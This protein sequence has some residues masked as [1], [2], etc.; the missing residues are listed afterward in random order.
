M[1]SLTELYRIGPGPSSSHTLGPQRAALMFKDEFK[2]ATSYK[3]ILYGSLALTGKGHYTDQILIKTMLPIPCEIVFHND[4]EKLKHPNTLVFYAYK[5]S[6]CIGEW[7]V[8]SV[9]GGS[10]EIEGRASIDGKKLYQENTFQAIHNYCDQQNMS[11]AQYIDSY[12]QID[13]YLETIMNQMLSTVYQGINQDGLLPGELQL[14]RVAKE[15]YENAQ[16][17][18][19]PI[20]KEQLLLSAYAY[21]ASEENAA[22]GMMVT[23]PTLGSSGVLP[24]LLYYFYYDKKM[25]K[26]DMIDALK[27]A[28]IFGNL[29]KENATISGA[30][31]GCQAEIGAACAMG[32][33]FCASLYK[34]D[35]AKIE[36]AAEIGIE[37][38]LGLTCDPVGGHVM[39]PCIERN[40]VAALRA[41]D[42][43]VLIKGMG[44]IKTNR[45][46][47]DMVVSVMKYTGSKLAIELK[48]TSLG[49]LATIVPLI[50]E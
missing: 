41:K 31:G 29:I 18:K 17:T 16:L 11:L 15:L 6:Q 49:G 7:T 4:S 38:H 23:A 45:V 36:S 24:S 3:V 9:G 14:K 39:I 19:D 13:D 22:G 27:V 33:A 8:Y 40:A 1:K 26:Q 50:K 32:A 2:D 42:A 21:A 46:S 37:H 43:A 12:E 30:Q 48:E 25:P 10:I 34:L 35:I 44:N 5:N 47:F 28:G 20:E